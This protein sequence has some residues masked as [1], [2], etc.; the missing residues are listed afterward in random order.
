MRNLKVDYC[1]VKSGEC[2]IL[3]TDGVSDNFDPEQMGL[4]PKEVGIEC[5]E[6][7]TWDKLKVEDAINEKCKWSN[8]KMEEILNNAKQPYDLKNKV[9]PTKIYS[10]AIV[11]HCCDST[12][13]ARSKNFFIFLFFFF[14]IFFFYFY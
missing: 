11:R 3:V 6:D 14:F 13:N 8:K 2:L 1:T 5:L 4:S 9:P 12:F 7:T 10:H